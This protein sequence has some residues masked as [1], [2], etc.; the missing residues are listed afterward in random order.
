MFMNQRYTCYEN[1]F[2][3]LKEMDLCRKLFL[4][5]NK[6]KGWVGLDQPQVGGDQGWVA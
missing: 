5:N 3:F 1:F 2:F 4:K 6:T